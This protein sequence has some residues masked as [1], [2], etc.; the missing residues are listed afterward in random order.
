MIAALV[1][2]GRR[3]LPEGGRAKRR[4][5]RTQKWPTQNSPTQDK[6][7]RRPLLAADRVTPKTKLRGYITASL[8]SFA[9]RKATFLLALMW[10]VS[11]VAGLRPSRA[12]RLRT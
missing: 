6:H 12:A 11:P 3:H 5:G 8:S 10:M 1:D 9:A 2:Q 7:Y 4:I